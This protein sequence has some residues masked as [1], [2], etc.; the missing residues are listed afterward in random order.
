MTVA[1]DIGTLA[2]PALVVDANTPCESLEATFRSRCDLTAVIVAD[3]DRVGLI[4]RGRFDQAMSG[5]F[6][7]GRLLWRQRP[8]SAAA[9]W[10]PLRLPGATTVA[11]ASHLLRTRPVEHRYDDAVVKL[12]TDLAHGLGLRVTA[13]G[14]ENAA[15][16]YELARL[17]VINAQGSHLAHPMPLGPDQAAG[18]RNRGAAAH[19]PPGSLRPEPSA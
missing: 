3:G 16:L 9:D 1:G 6:G 7:Y 19:R 17:G 18:R 15:Q 14:V 13:E 8:V 5:P 12:L 11:A 2:R 10:K 4:M